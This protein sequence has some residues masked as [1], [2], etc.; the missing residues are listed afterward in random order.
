MPLEKCEESSWV[1]TPCRI[2]PGAIF[3]MTDICKMTVLAMVVFTDNKL[4]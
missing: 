4:S 2:D 3:F 1:F